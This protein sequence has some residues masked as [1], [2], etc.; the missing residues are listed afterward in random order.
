MSTIVTTWLRFALQQMAAESY[1]DGINILDDDQVEGRLLR[2]N[3]RQGFD[4][5]SGILTGATRFTSVL[6]DQFLESYQLVDHHANDSTGF[7]ATLVQEIGT[8][9]FTLSFF[10]Y[11]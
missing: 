3:N 9:N 4:P 8:N 6:A 7:S 10:V 1:L 5:P 11:R 2:G